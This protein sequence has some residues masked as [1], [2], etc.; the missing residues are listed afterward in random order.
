MSWNSAYWNAM[1]NIFWTLDY[2]GLKRIDVEKVPGLPDHYVVRKADMPNGLVYTR[3]R[4]A[5]MMPDHLG[6]REETL[7]HIV[8]IALAMA[9]DALISRL[10]AEPLGIQDAGPFD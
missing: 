6:S 7:N 1:S 9:P 2:V 10:I 8:D 4:T 5:A 3:C